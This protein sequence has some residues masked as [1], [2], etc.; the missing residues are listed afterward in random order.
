[1]A[2]NV[3][4]TVNPAHLTGHL[5]D[6][7]VVNSRYRYTPAKNPGSGS[8][9]NIQYVPVWTDPHWQD[10]GPL[11][12]KSDFKIKHSL[13][14]RLRAAIL[15]R[16]QFKQPTKY[17]QR[18]SIFPGRSDGRSRTSPTRADSR[19]LFPALAQ[20]KTGKQLFERFEQ[21]A[22]DRPVEDFM[23]QERLD[24]KALDETEQQYMQ[25]YED[26][27]VDEHWQT[28]LFGSLTMDEL[29]ENPQ[30]QAED[31]FKMSDADLG[32]LSGP[33]YSLLDRHKWANTNW[34]GDKNHPR[35]L[36]SING[37]REEWSPLTNDRV[38]EAMQ[39]A[40]Q[41]ATR[42]LQS[43]DP[44]TQALQNVT[45]RFWIDSSLYPNDPNTYTE[46]RTKFVRDDSGMTGRV[47]G[48]QALSQDIGFS[49]MA[50]SWQALNQVLE[51]RLCSGFHHW[52]EYKSYCLGR[53]TFPSLTDPSSK[54][55]IYV[56]A[57]L[58]WILMVDK[59]SKSEK[60]MASFVLA[61]TLAHEMM[62]AWACVPG[63]WLSNPRWFGITDPSHITAC[64]E[65]IDELAPIGCWIGEPHFEDD[66][67][68]EVGHA[69][70]DHVL[71]GG[72]WPFVNGGCALNPLPRFFS[73]SGLVVSKCHWPDGFASMTPQLFKPLIRPISLNHFVRSGETQK[74]FAPD[75]WN[76]AFHKYG[77]A[78]LRESSSKPHKVNYN[79]VDQFNWNHVV[80]K[81]NLGTP[82]DR[83]WISDFLTLV[84]S[85]NHDALHAYL[86]CLVLEAC[87]F[88]LMLERFHIHS[89]AWND[90][91][92][93]LHELCRE[94]LMIIY[95]T[96]AS[97]VQRT[98]DQ[99]SNNP[100][101]QEQKALAVR[102]LYEDWQKV[103]Q[104]LGRC[105][106]AESTI[107]TGPLDWWARQVELWDL[108]H[109]EKRLIPKLLD[110]IR[111]LEI[112]CAHQESMVCELYHLP[113][114]FWK[115]Y[116]TRLPDHAIQWCKRANAISRRITSIYR[117]I[118]VVETE[119]P[120]WSTE[121]KT[122]ITSIETRFTNIMRLLA[123]NERNYEE[124]WRDLVVSMP[125][126]RKSRQKPHQRWYFLAKKEMMDMSGVE[127]GE[128]KEFKIRFQ[129]LLNLGSYKV[130]VPDMDPDELD[131][132]Q[133][134]AGTLDDD[135]QGNGAL[136]GAIKNP[137]TGIFDTEAVRQIAARLQRDEQA[138][139]DAILKRAEEGDIKGPTLQEIAEAEATQAPKISPK[140]QSMSMENQVAPLSGIRLSGSG[141]NPFGSYAS[142]P[143]TFLPAY[144][145]GGPPAWEAAD[146]FD[147]AHGANQPIGGI[148]PSS[149]PGHG[150]MPHPYAV[151]ETITQDLQNSAL[152]KLPNRHPSDFAGDEPRES[153]THHGGE[154]VQGTGLLGDV[155]QAWEQQSRSPEQR[156]AQLSSLTVEQ[157]VL[158][159]L[160]DEVN[161]DSATGSTT[162]GQ[163]V[164]MT[165]APATGHLARALDIIDSSSSSETELSS[166]GEEEVKWTSESSDTS[167]SES[168]SED[169]GKGESG[170]DEEPT[171]SEGSVEEAKRRSLKRKASLAAVQP[172]KPRKQRTVI[173]RS[174]ARKPRAGVRL[175]RGKLARRGSEEERLSSK[176]TS[177]RV[178]G[179]WM[180]G[181]EW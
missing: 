172:W 88:D 89:Y 22:G 158:M 113:T 43:D 68:A 81:S 55:T 82:E 21:L 149:L 59:Y 157:R 26:L 145:S 53:T 103:R 11:R 173:R 33:L 144:Q 1:M 132:A 165:D 7:N 23:E 109:Y 64:K 136:G 44:F 6:P 58:V 17:A 120:A 164:D 93:P 34:D 52:G 111:K 92:K 156:R 175:A 140:I 66:A 47:N 97:S 123:L 65:L 73:P 131:I 31:Y 4:P 153:T 167:A 154:S 70:E 48:A 139:Q 171:P 106:D 118:E 169:E 107:C 166:A 146:E 95:E 114:Q 179:G 161:R 170:K 94:A 163:D 99:A 138:A 127:L 112:E 54:I 71:G 14:D 137:S 20:V 152:L 168:V 125:R 18:F 176:L 61:T 181:E 60:M 77:A 162:G 91:D 124:H 85:N 42:L 35:L 151:R 141:A 83:K 72:Y 121:W 67:A 80:D 8:W 79:P 90:T 150:I 110:F 180:G 28:I 10:E 142:G 30:M 87:E 46:P 133:R 62:H 38:W 122:R 41:L 78:V 69:F 32:Q 174:R 108:E 178:G 50:E 135:H 63:K 128:L 160:V 100:R 3:N 134:L 116:K 15:T 105:P 24:M 74:Y 39:P 36:Y 148:S 86:S 177:S 37:V 84:D 101:L 76:V 119:L 143:A 25:Q 130:V 115:H 159:F 13:I 51:L 27:I 29:T 155:S 19:Q 117:A 2:S 147:L 126:L 56:D 129:N 96:A 40:L 104:K 57:E 5:P 75:F 98:M 9:D 12:D 16:D 49:A 45:N 102:V